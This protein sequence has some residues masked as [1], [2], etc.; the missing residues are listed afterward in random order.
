MHFDQWEE[1]TFLATYMCIEQVGE[2]HNGLAADIT[3]C[4]FS[5]QRQR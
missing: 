4:D 3:G 2:L 5:S 1:L